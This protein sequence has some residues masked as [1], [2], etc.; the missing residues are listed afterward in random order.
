M[1]LTLKIGGMVFAP[2][3]DGFIAYRA[4]GTLRELGE[5]SK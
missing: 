1:A 5:R 4:T 3:D 2:Q